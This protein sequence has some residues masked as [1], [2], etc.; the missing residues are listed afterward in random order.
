MD[1]RWRDVI[2]L[3]LLHNDT[4]QCVLDS[5]QLVENGQKRPKPLYS[6]EIFDR[7][8][9]I[10]SPTAEPEIGTLINLDARKF[11]SVS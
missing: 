5:L 1:Q 6:V 2:E 9:K 4:S 8:E 11:N 3:F 7:R 10:R